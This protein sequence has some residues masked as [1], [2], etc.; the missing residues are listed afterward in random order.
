MP[1]VLLL[2]YRTKPTF[3]GAPGFE[4]GG[5]PKL[6]GAEAVAQAGNKAANEA[7]SNDIRCIVPPPSLNKRT[8]RPTTTACNSPVRG[9]QFNP[10]QSAHRLDLAAFEAADNARL[11]QDK[12]PILGQLA[13]RE[14]SVQHWKQ[15]VFS[16][17][18]GDGVEL[19]P[20]MKRQTIAP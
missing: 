17:R 12:L 13:E 2:V 15:C 14:S 5:A 7:A 10:M 6:V 1:G 9:A 19:S 16:H 4:A 20:E 18:S 8:I 11:D 3:S